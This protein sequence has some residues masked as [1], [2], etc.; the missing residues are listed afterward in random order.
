M[1]E[2]RKKECSSRRI[3]RELKLLLKNQN[4]KKFIRKIISPP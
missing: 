1:E 4:K 2:E 3:K